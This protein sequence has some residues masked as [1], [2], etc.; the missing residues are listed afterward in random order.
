[1]GVVVACSAAGEAQDKGQWRA[2]SSNARAITG[3]VAITDT[4]VA[5][6]FVSFTIARIRG[7]EASE[8]AAAFDAEGAAAES[9]SLYRLSVPATTKFLHKN[10]L[11]GSDETE[12][13]LTYVEGK[14][15]HVAFFSSK[16]TPVLTRDAISN[17]TD[18]CGTFTYG[19]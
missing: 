17:S 3:D 19:R 5:I 6:N 16:Q 7:L 11:C 2:V 14:S 8:I 9:G 18:V 13:M 15:L 12:W 4:K 1:M 10:S